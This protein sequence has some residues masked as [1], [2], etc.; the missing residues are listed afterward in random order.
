MR[1]LS[2]WIHEFLV[3]HTFCMTHPSRSLWFNNPSMIITLGSWVEITLPHGRMDTNSLRLC[4]PLWVAVL[5][6]PIA[7]PRSWNATRFYGL[8]AATRRTG[9]PSPWWFVAPYNHQE[10][11]NQFDIVERSRLVQH[12]YLLTYRTFGA[13]NLIEIY[14]NSWLCFW[15]LESFEIL[16][17]VSW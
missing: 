10:Y 15:V 14:S 1:I 8:D 13:N 7:C 16:D 2:E 3:H 17:R 9:D 4:I 11:N 6:M 12:L 5:H